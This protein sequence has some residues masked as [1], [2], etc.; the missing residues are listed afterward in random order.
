MAKTWK[1]DCGTPGRVVDVPEGQLCQDCGRSQWR[2]GRWTIAGK[3]AL[4]DAV[5]E[6]HG[7]EMTASDYT[8]ILATGEVPEKFRLT[9]K[10]CDH[11]KELMKCAPMKLLDGR[12]MHPGCWAKIEPTQRLA[13]ERQC[14]SSIGPKR[15]VLSEGH[16]REHQFMAGSALALLELA[17][18]DALPKSM[19]VPAGVVL[20]APLEPGVLVIEG[21]GK[22]EKRKGQNM[23]MYESIEGMTVEDFREKY[24]REP[25]NIGDDER[26]AICEVAAPRKLGFHPHRFAYDGAPGLVPSIDG[27]MKVFYPWPDPPPAAIQMEH[28]NICTKCGKRVAEY[29]ALLKSPGVTEHDL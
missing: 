26:C 25:Q 15:C 28:S 22:L 24:K 29:I 2:P 17:P 6:E 14:T 27:W 4:A 19:V 11:C 10:L 9:L 18:I 20:D 5:L 23:A 1:C 3:I 16:E 12:R 7:A 21:G 8:K 13:P